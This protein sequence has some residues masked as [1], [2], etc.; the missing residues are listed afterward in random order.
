[1]RYRRFTAVG[2][3]LN[4]GVGFFGGSYVRTDILRS[5]DDEER[6]WRHRV[7]GLGYT[8]ELLVGYRLFRH[9]GVKAGVA[10]GGPAEMRFV[11]PSTVAVLSF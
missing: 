10:V 7:P 11:Q 4:A 3:E 6:S 2:I 5:P 8:A 1:M 9:L